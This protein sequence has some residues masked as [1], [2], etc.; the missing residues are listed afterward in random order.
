MIVHDAT[1]RISVLMITYKQEKVIGRTLDSLISQREYLYEICIND[2]CSPD[3]TWGII[4]EY[5]Q[6][7][8]EL[9]KPV[10]NE[11]NVGIFENIELTWER[12]TGD[13]VYQLA[14]DDEA[15]NGYFKA[16]LDYIEENRIDY[17]NELF[18]IYGDYKEVESDGREIIFKNS[19]VLRHDV[20]KLKLRMLISNRSACFSRRV[21][22]MFEKVSEGRSY[23]AELVQDNQL[24][25]FVNKNYYIPVVGNI[26]YAGIGV[27]A[28]MSR[29][30]HIANI[31]EGYQRLVCFMKSHGHPFN[32]K[33]IAYIEFW[34]SYRSGKKLAMLKWYV[35]SIDLSLGLKGLNIERIIFV[36]KKRMFK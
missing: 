24:Q 36:I 23:N 26:Y 19:M 17:K 33:D 18:C 15:G 11:K 31:N 21:I 5:A 16:V 27:S 30:D 35:K 32:R 13:I 9:I 22:E 34:K 7:Y 12:P 25:L 29:E 3:G 4:Q 8:P 20:M 28:R 14:G 1:P 10:K 2:D 6:R